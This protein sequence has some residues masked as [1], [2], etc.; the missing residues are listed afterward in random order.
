MKPTFAR[1]HNKLDAGRRKISA[2]KLLVQYPLQ[3]A[4][5]AEDVHTAIVSVAETLFCA[6][7]FNSFLY[8][9]KVLSSSRLVRRYARAVME[10]SKPRV[11]QKP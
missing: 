11:L 6:A 7:F 3:D 8:K 9:T 1:Q 5:G 2:T 4:F 10:L